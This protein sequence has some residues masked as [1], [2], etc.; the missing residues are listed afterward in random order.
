MSS[1]PVCQKIDLLLELIGLADTETNL[2]FRD[3]K[4]SRWNPASAEITVYFVTNYR[5]NFPTKVVDNSFSSISLKYY[6]K[7]DL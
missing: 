1:S 5:Q 7:S 4:T 3:L 6:S 2:M